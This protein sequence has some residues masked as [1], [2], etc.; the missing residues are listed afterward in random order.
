M[1][2][3]KQEYTDKEWVLRFDVKN[4]TVVVPLAMIKSSVLFLCICAIFIFAFNTGQL[5]AAQQVEYANYMICSEN[6]HAT[7]EGGKIVWD[8]PKL[9][10]S[11]NTFKYP[12]RIS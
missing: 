12:G 1:Q 7:A 4:T 11:A 6:C 10:D 5:A 2:I 8:C 9:N 3:A